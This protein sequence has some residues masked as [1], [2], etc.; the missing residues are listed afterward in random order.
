[1]APLPRAQV[2]STLLY[3]LPATALGDQA[4]SFKPAQDLGHRL[5]GADEKCRAAFNANVSCPRSYGSADDAGLDLY[6]TDSCFQSLAQY[7]DSVQDNCKGAIYEIHQTGHVWQPVILADEVLLDRKY[8][9]RK[10]SDGGYCERPWRRDQDQDTLSCSQ[11]NLDKMRLFAEYAGY[12]DL[13]KAKRDYISLASECGFDDPPI[14][15]MPDIAIYQPQPYSGSEGR[16][17]QFVEL[18]EDDTW[19]SLSLKHQ[20]STRELTTRNRLDITFEGLHVR[21]TVICLGRKCQVYAIKEGDTC[22]SITEAAGLGL[23]EL[24]A[25]NPSIASLCNDLSD[26]VNQ[27]ICLSNFDDEEAISRV[28]KWRKKLPNG[29]GSAQSPLDLEPGQDAFLPDDL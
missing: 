22:D 9:C 16:C 21:K 7:R 26:K 14:N 29:Q 23:D 18:K 13:E 4:S 25:W 11:C 20:V 3:L 28:P 15:P 12:Y 17:K 6:C 1:M 8:M 19:L 2:L 27:T 24:L 5:A 10:T